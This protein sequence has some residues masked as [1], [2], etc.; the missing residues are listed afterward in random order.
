MIVER[1]WFSPPEAIAMPPRSRPPARRV[2]SARPAPPH[3][4]SRLSGDLEGPRFS[5]AL[6]RLLD[7]WIRIPGTR[8]RFGLDPLIGLF[9][10]IGD[11]VA[12][13]LGAAILA[14]A[15]RSGV[16]PRDLARMAGNILANSLIGAVPGVGDLLS[17]WF[18]SNRRNVDL[19][20]EALRARRAEPPDGRGSGISRGQ[21]VMALALAGGV[22]LVGIAVTVGSFLLL[23][24]LVASWAP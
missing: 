23:A 9:P 6:A 19:M 20:R 2:P 14:D 1:G 8:I 18:K 10:G 7:D 3:P 5:R 11:A 22:A 13:V 12:T 24:R 17:V 21:A 4:S 15:G 16:A